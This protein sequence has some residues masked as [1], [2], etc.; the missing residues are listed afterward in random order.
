MSE[1][2]P[3]QPNTRGGSPPYTRTA[4]SLRAKR[5]NLPEGERRK[6]TRASQMPAVAH[7]LAR[8][9]SAPFA[10]K[11][12]AAGRWRPAL[13][14]ASPRIG[15]A[16]ISTEAV[17]KWR[18]PREKCHRSNTNIPNT[19]PRWLTA[20][21]FP[22]VE[23]ARRISA[24]AHSPAVAHRRT[25]VPPCHCE[26]SVAISR[27]G[28]VGNAPAPAKCPRW[29]T[30]EKFPTVETETIEHENPEYSPAAA[31]RREIPRE[32][33]GTPHIRA[34]SLAR[35]G[36]APCPQRLTAFRSLFYHKT[37]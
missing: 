30:A 28:N 17:A 23:T 29:L 8:A 13:P 1:P 4:L 33:N 34:G 35:G 5:G 3:R 15:Y 26:R 37:N 25:P 22:T 18:P 7:R 11:H 14:T 19:R 31:L 27:K 36:S 2:Y 16:V 24:P 12:Y 21:K 6:R 10:V 20:E 9:G 32:R